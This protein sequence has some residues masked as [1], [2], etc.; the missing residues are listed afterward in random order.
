[1]SGNDQRRR[2]HLSETE[3]ALWREV[4]RAV[5]PLKRAKRKAAEESEAASAEAASAKSAA[6]SSLAKPAKAEAVTS[7]HPRAAPQP[8]VPKPKPPPPPA[9]APL[10]RRFKQRLA[11]G[12]KAIDARIDLHGMTQAEAHAALARFLHRA[13]AD[14]AKVVLVITGKGK[15]GDDGERERGVLRRQVPQWL[16]MPELRDLV[17]GFEEAAI[18]HG[19]E[20]ALYVRVRRGRE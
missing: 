17:V 11:R 20:G 19:G 10:D 7:A 1:M 5:A 16:R 9:L 8:P 13:Q 18:G 2:K 15:R 3:R 14:G 6:K 12:T 4:T